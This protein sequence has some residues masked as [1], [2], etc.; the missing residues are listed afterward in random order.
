[1]VALR[2]FKDWLLAE[3]RQSVDPHTLRSFE[4]IFEDELERLIQRCQGNPALQ[5]TLEPMRA[6]PVKTASGCTRWTDY[7]LG[8]IIRHCAEKVHL[9]DAFAYVMFR[10]LSRT[11][12][13]GQPRQC[14][15]DMDPNRE[16]DLNIGNPL[17]A[18]FRRFLINDVR[19][20]AAGKIRRLMLKPN[21]MPTIS[22]APGRKK[23]KQ[24]PGSIRAEEIPAPDTD[25]KWLELQNDIVSL[26][27]RRSTPDMPLVDLFYAV[28]NGTGTREQRKRFGHS[29]ADRGR[30]II[31]DTLLAYARSSGNRHL[32]NLLIRFKDFKANQ[33]DPNSRRSQK[34]VRPPRP[35]IT[36]S[37]Q[38]RDF[39][40]IVQVVQRHGGRASLAVLGSQRARW[41]GRSPRDPSSSAKTRLHDVLDQMVQAGV[42]AKQ[43]ANYIP[44]PNYGKYLDAATS[45]QQSPV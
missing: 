1:M 17:L 13:R 31:Y 11:G 8:A 35:M 15:F 7:A 40:S 6:C 36:L 42:L 27:N 9:E 24:G 41:L 25:Q 22:I 30:K 21:R 3:E 16:Y 38:E 34:K 5:R 23:G 33:A 18:R 43:G 44:G 29:V 28:L 2:D 10:L 20:I 19:S 12:E 39:R 4:R 37:P 32:E 45:I 26:L 14:L